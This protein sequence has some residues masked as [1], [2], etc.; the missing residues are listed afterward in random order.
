MTKQSEMQ[1]MLDSMGAPIIVID[2]PE[3][4]RRRSLHSHVDRGPGEPACDHRP[5]NS[6]VDGND[7]LGSWRPHPVR[8]HTQDRCRSQRI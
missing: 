5:G 6:P 1:A 2:A 4:V 3:A 8:V 7:G